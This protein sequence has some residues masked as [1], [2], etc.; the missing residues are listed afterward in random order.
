MECGF[1]CRCGFAS[2]TEESFLRHVLWSL[3]SPAAPGGD[4]QLVGGGLPGKE[5]D[6]EEEEEEEEEEVVVEGT[7]HH[8]FLLL[9]LFLL[10][11]F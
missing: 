9:F 1:V 4:H 7:P 11:P 5:Q 8:L 3:Q 6:V 2:G 10:F